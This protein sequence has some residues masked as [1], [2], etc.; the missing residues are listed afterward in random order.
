MTL[1]PK[2]PTHWYYSEILDFHEQAQAKD[3]NYGYNYGHFTIADNLSISDEK[4]RK[5]AH[6]YEKGTVW[7]DRDI[8]RLAQNRRG[9]R[10]P[11]ILRSIQKI[12]SLPPM[13]CR[14]AFKWVAV[15]FF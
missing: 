4:L 3:M 5:N 11:R 1:N 10:I 6:D 12:I 9:D 8:K 13:S 7:Y 2:S 15:E 14:K